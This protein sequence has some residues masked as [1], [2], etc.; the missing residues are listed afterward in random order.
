MRVRLLIMFVSSCAISHPHRFDSKPYKTMGMCVCVCVCVCGGGGISINCAFSERKRVWAYVHPVWFREFYTNRI[1]DKPWGRR[2]RFRLELHRSSSSPS[3]HDFIDGGKVLFHVL[4]TPKC[5]LAD[6]RAVVRPWTEAC[7]Y[8]QLFKQLIVQEAKGP[9][10]PG[11]WCIRRPTFQFELQ[12][13]LCVHVWHRNP[14]VIVSASA[15]Q[16]RMKACEHQRFSW[17]NP[18][19]PIDVL[20]TLS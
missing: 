9:V 15:I 18:T 20:P 11:L 14:N 7:G 17:S 4:G 1:S 13:H 3:P 5:S 6:E 10:W 19:R 16:M 2:V 12:L 8:A